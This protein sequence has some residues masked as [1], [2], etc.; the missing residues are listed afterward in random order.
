MQGVSSLLS[1]RLA[2]ASLHSGI[3]A[4]RQ[5]EAL[6]GAQDAICAAFV[7]DFVSHGR[8]FSLGSFEFL[9]AV[10][11]N[12]RTIFWNVT[13]CSPIEVYSRFIVRYT[14]LRGT[15]IQNV[16]WLMPDLTVSHPKDILVVF[17]CY[18]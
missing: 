4:A 15:C 2:S 9:T 3:T 17:H 12:R 16:C 13:P 6:P 10:T 1:A 18:L 5:K 8:F 7:M 14:Y 11:M